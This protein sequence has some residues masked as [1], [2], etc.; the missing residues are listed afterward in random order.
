MKMAEERINQDLNLMIPEGYRVMSAEEM[1]AMFLDDNPNRW[2]M[3]NEAMHHTVA[4]FYHKSNPFLSMLAD[5][6]SV[7]ESTQLRLA[8]G[9]LSHQYQKGESF[10]LAMCGQKAYGFTY[11]YINH[12]VPTDGT[13][14]VFKHGNICYTVYGYSA[15]EY[16]ETNRP[17]FE[18]ICKSMHF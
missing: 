9:L 14:I 2:T 7:A 3:R 13:V 12:E 15:A 17:M 18:T 1:Q 5:A 10:P 4:V 11:R 16:T 6:K 8:E